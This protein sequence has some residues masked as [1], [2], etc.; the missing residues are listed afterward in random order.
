MHLKQH[1]HPSYLLNNRFLHRHIAQRIV[2]T[3]MTQNHLE[4]GLQRRLVEAWKR[5]AGIERLELC[6]R[7]PSSRG[8]NLHVST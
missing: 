5:S 1:V 6:D 3:A 8:T 4:L 2:C 7:H